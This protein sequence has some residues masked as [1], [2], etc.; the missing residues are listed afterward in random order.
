MPYKGLYTIVALIICVLIY[1]KIRNK[2]NT[3]GYI[4]ITALIATIICNFFIP[5]NISIFDT[6]NKTEDTISNTEDLIP[7]IELSTKTLELFI[8]DEDILTAI[9]SPDDVEINWYSSNEEIVMVD[10]NGHIKA[11]SEGSAEITATIVYGEIEDTATC[12]ITVKSPCIDLDTTCVLDI[13]ESIT[14]SA[15]TSPESS[16]TWTS[17]DSDIATVNDKGEVAG[18]NEGTATIT[19]AM[20]YNDEEYSA[21]CDITIK[22]PIDESDYILNN[23]SKSNEEGDLEEIES[24]EMS[25]GNVPWLKKDNINKNMSATTMRGEV[26]D[27]CIGLGS[28]N[29]NADSNAAIIAACDQKYSRFTA[30]IAPQEGFDESENVT[31]YI[32]GGCDDEQ[33]FVEKYTIDFMTET[34]LVDL[35]IS[36]AK[37]LYIIKS[38]NYNQGRI[39]GQFINGY[40]GMGVLIHNATLYKE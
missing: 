26:W 40:T 3:L 20:T 16:I 2:K 32:Y 17:S 31:L 24:T 27:N 18:V 29:I 6:L 15:L 23:E 8:T 37:E 10:S 7:D 1:L 12:N 30:E 34:F 5:S 4:I 33:T 39:A 25:L 19:A 35:D 13:G 21:D 36:G 11:V 38:G 22:A 28:S 9:T 14:L